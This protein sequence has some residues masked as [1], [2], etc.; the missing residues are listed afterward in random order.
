MILLT[1]IDNNYISWYRQKKIT[2][3]NIMCVNDRLL[4]KTVIMLILT[5]Y[6]LMMK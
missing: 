4:N 5:S 6:V 2:L 1:I 3:N